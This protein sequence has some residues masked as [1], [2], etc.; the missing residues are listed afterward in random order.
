MAWISSSSAPIARGPRS[1][2]LAGWRRRSEDPGLRQSVACRSL[3]SVRAA[4]TAPLR[5]VAFAGDQ[6]AVPAEDRVGRDEAGDLVEDLAAEDP[7]H[8]REAPA[9]VI[10]QPKTASAHLLSEDSVLLHRVVD[11]PVPVPV[12]P[13]GAQRQE[14][15]EGSSRT[16]SGL[17][18][19]TAS[20]QGG[21]SSIP[22]EPV[23]CRKTA[24]S[25]SAELWHPTSSSSPSQSER[26]QT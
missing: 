3:G 9:L 11:D 8:H 5:A 2:L 15:G 13:P 4:G 20:R 26:S 7:A 22:M 23:R 6:L 19:E 14:E 17:R 18:A 21:R 1:R 16:W 12:H 24:V 10:G 25:L